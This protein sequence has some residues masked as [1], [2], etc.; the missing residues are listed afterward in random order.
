M[1]NLKE[2]KQNV[3]AFYEMMVNDCQPAQAIAK[4]AGAEY[5]QHNSHIADGKQAFID[6]F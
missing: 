2:N 5:I 1:P 6:Y 3:I 4:F